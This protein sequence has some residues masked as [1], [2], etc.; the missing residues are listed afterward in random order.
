MILEWKTNSKSYWVPRSVLNVVNA[1]E[2]AAT[3]WV[4]TLSRARWQALNMRFLIRFSQQ[5]YR[6]YYYSHFTDRETEV[7]GGEDLPKITQ[8]GN[9]RD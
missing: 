1:K 2:A 5:S 9:G 7:Q 3:R 8:P 4:L 6:R